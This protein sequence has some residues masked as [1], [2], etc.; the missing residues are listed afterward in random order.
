MLI[1]NNEYNQKS[2]HCYEQYKD[3]SADVFQ[4]MQKVLKLH[5]TFS[6]SDGMGSWNIPL[7]TK[8]TYRCYIANAV[9]DDDVATLRT[10]ASKPS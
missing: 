2:M 9:V 10:M 4:E 7:L 1:H 6:H 8:R 5:I 3:L